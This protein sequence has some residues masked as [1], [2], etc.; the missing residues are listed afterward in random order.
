MY[1]VY[2]AGGRRE[3]KRVARS[4]KRTVCVRRTWSSVYR[5]TEW[6]WSWFWLFNVFYVSRS[7]CFCFVFLVSARSLLWRLLPLAV[8]FWLRF[9]CLGVCV[10][11]VVILVAIMHVGATAALVARC[12]HGLALALACVYVC[13]LITIN[14]SFQPA[15]PST[16]S[17][18]CRFFVLDRHKLSM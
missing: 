4:R 12:G 17:V 13:V 5:T 15:T 9:L 1:L 16:R 3:S 8:D 6:F 11:V 7:V 14:R 10:P 18:P 2:I